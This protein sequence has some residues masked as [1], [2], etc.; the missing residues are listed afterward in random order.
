MAIFVVSLQSKLTYKLKMDPTGPIFE[1]KISKKFEK[2][3]RYFYKDAQSASK[4]VIY[5]PSVGNANRGL[6][7]V[8]LVPQP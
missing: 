7:R 4:T 5:A 8:I 3:R 2:Y 1:K 6:F